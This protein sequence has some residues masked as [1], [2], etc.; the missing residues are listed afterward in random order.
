MG[1]VKEFKEFALRG[2]VVDLAV[3]I[4]IGGAFQKIVTSIVGDILMPPIGKAM[5]NVD[6]SSLFVSLDPT[7]TEGISSLAKAKDSGAAIIAYGAFLNT[8]IDFLIVAF[9]VF[10]LVKAMNQLKKPGEKPPA[11]TKECPE[12][13]SNIPL[14]AKRCAHCTSVIA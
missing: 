7:K 6:F 10:L 11:T 5:G 13:L 2:N 1:M 8:V 14:Q 9:C 12:C 4:I 3:G